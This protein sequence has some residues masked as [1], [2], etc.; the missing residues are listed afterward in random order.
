ME[1]S[2]VLPDFTRTFTKAGR[3][4]LTLELPKY[5]LMIGR[6]R[7][8]GFYLN[9]YDKQ[10]KDYEFVDL[11]LYY[12]DGTDCSK[13]RRYNHTLKSALVASECL[14]NPELSVSR[15][16]KLANEHPKLLNIYNSYFCNDG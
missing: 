14:A 10:E 7:F 1:S 15:A 11:M 4:T 9:K 2:S 13:I 16:Y 8:G 6:N 3:P 12:L 5:R